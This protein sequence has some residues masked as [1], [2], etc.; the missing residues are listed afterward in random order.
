MPSYTPSES[1][2]D[3]LLGLSPN[4]SKAFQHRE[5]NRFNSLSQQLQE[6]ID[7]HY[8]ENTDND[9]ADPWQCS[10]EE[11][12]FLSQ[13]EWSINFNAED[14]TNCYEDELI[15]SFDPLSSS[16]SLKRS[17]GL[18]RSSRNKILNNSSQR[19]SK[20]SSCLP[21]WYLSETPDHAAII[22]RQYNHKILKE[23][24]CPFQPDCRRLP[25]FIGRIQRSPVKTCKR[26]SPFQT[27]DKIDVYQRDIRQCGSP[28][29]KL[30][31]TYALS[32][33]N[34]DGIPFIIEV[35]DSEQISPWRRKIN[36]RYPI[37]F[38]YG[39]P[40]WESKKEFQY[41]V[42]SEEHEVGYA[43][44]PWNYTAYLPT[45]FLKKSLDSEDIN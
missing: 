28:L 41:S 29:T 15:F 13:E 40:V 19:S 43:C 3:L 27:L 31:T 17:S 20:K 24:Y 42:E 30:S 14:F 38:I 45:E 32:T 2:T 44:Q 6:E 9:E 1:P 36:R 5:E 21:F 4:S 7:D 10:D 39:L 22:V 8:N 34:K 33:W 35:L 25:H 37:S 18:K 11:N 16:S 12:D 26:E 23:D